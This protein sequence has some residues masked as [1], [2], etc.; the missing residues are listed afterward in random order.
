M[1]VQKIIPIEDKPKQ[2]ATQSS[3]GIAMFAAFVVPF[4]LLVAS[5][6]YRTFVAQARATLETVSRQ[7]PVRFDSKVGDQP[8]GEKLQPKTGSSVLPRSGSGG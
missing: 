7:S 3:L 8:Q 2:T 6:R 5:T 4:V 1:S